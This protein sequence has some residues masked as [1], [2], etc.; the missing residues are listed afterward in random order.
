MKVTDII[1]EAKVSIKDQILA[2]VRK[3]GPGEYFVRTTAVDKLGFSAK[4]LFGR[5]PDMDDPK[6]DVDYIGTNKGRPALWFYPLKEY[7]RSKDLYATDSPYTWL[8]KLR[9]DAWLQPANRGA[10]GIAKPPQGK[11][12][13]GIMRMSSPPAAIFFT[14]AFDVVGKYYDYAGQHQRHGQVKG[15]ESQPR[16]WF[17]RV[18]GYQ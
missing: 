13:V 6:F 7:I 4:Q 3:H 10:R 17:D 8:V 9:D 18:R 14:P 15:P 12:R 11:Q 2:D 16:S 5:T 1:T